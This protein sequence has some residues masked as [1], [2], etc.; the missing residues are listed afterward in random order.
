MGS[1]HIA[2]LL[3]EANKKISRIIDRLQKENAS[4]TDRQDW[5]NDLNT[6]IQQLDHA[7]EELEKN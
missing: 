7:V 1:K 3:I 4:S 6:I 5:I 2:E